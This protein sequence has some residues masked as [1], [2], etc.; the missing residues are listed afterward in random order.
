MRLQ[1]IQ[2]AFHSLGFLSRVFEL[3]IK[4]VFC[5][6]FLAEHISAVYHQSS[7]KVSLQQIR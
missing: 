5:K 6:V 4:L 2:V 1:L 3:S 7:E